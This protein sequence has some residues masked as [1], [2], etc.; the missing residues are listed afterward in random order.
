MNLYSE[1]GLQFVLYEFVFRVAK[2]EK[3]VCDCV[4]LTKI[5]VYLSTIN[6]EKEVRK[7]RPQTQEWRQ[8]ESRTLEK[9]EKNISGICGKSTDDP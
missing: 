7:K 8:C 3:S 2:I 5:R 1:L 4:N 9:R 6:K